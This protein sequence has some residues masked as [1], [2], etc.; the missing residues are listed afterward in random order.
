MKTTPMSHD[1]RYW[2]EFRYWFRSI[3]K[4]G[5]DPH[6][7]RGVIAMPRDRWCG[8]SAALEEV[9]EREKLPLY[10]RTD[11]DFDEILFTEEKS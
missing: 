4:D 5:S 7:F 8:D 2:K 1:S 6:D 10:P 9:V 11:V 3:P